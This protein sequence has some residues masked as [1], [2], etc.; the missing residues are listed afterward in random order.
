[1]KKISKDY[2]E[3]IEQLENLLGHVKDMA[4]DGE[5]VWTKDAKALQE[6]IDIVSDYEKAAKQAS[7]VI[8]KYEFAE[9]V[10]ERGEDIYVCPVCGKRSQP[11]HTHCHWCGK[12]LLWS[13]VPRRIKAG[14]KREWKK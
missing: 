7:E 2:K 3:I 10:I 5:E 6:A 13:S 4:R 9:P 14:G 12:K 11:G 8:Q 1:M